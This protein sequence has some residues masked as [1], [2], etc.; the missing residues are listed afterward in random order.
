MDFAVTSPLQQSNV[1][2]A[3]Q[4]QLSAAASYENKKLADRN[5]AERCRQHGFRLV[6]MVAESRGGWGTSAQKAFKWLAHAR[7]ARTGMSVSQVT[8]ELYSG[9]S[10]ILMRANARSLL[11]RTVAPEASID[12]AIQGARTELAATA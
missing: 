1:S 9:L 2:L 12:I 5:T 8:V 6:P 10:V 7:A 11:A 4:E 3:A